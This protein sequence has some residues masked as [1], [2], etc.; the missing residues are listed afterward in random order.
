MLKYRIVSKKTNLS[1]LNCL[2]FYDGVAKLAFKIC[3]NCYFLQRQIQQVKQYHT[4]R[5]TYAPG[6][7]HTGQTITCSFRYH[8]QPSPSFHLVL[9]LRTLS[10]PR[11]YN[12]FKAAPIVAY[13]RSSDLSDFLVRAKL[14]NLTQHN[15]PWGSYP[16][17]KNCFTCKYISDGQ[18]L[19]TFHFTGE[20][21]PITHH[22]D[23]N[24]KN[25]IVYWS[26]SPNPPQSQNITLIILPLGG[27]TL[28]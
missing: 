7:F 8:L 6:H 4:Y 16:C 17:G 10:S 25:R 5:S 24:S 11:F 12:V 3:V 1:Y 15:Q 19:Y 22:I 20:T 28:I 27:L 9:Y 23:C 2:I 26:T 14:R 13:R 21:G 18:T